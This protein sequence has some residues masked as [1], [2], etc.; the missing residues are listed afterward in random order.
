M[1]EK[2]GG[3]IHDNGTIKIESNS[4]SKSNYHPKNLVDY[5]SDNFYY[6]NNEI[7]ANICFDFKDK[8]V[9]ISD[10]SIKSYDQESYTG[11][12]KDWNIDVSNNGEN[13]ITIDSHKNDQTLNGRNIVATFNVQ[14]KDEQFYRFVRLSQTGNN[15]NGR[16][17]NFIYFYCIEFY[18]KLKESL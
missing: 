8:K 2:T 12:L 10:Y 7:L 18:G 1:T 5:E 11:H 4:L 15:W 17:C 6:S 9:N 14:N 3:N 16:N 13:W